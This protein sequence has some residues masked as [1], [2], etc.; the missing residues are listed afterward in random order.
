MP[1]SQITG[2]LQGLVTSFQTMRQMGIHYQDKKFLEMYEI[3][4]IEW[5]LTI[6]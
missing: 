5:M 6:F 2:V 3:L 1:M 4:W